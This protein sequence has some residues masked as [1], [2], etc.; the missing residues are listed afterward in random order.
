MNDIETV[1]SL[2]VKESEEVARLK[3]EYTKENWKKVL[4]IS[5]YN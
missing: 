3:R 1:I 5:L 2:L 4:M